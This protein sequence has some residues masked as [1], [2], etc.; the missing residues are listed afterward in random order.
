MSKIKFT[1]FDNRCFTTL[2]K[3]INAPLKIKRT[4]DVSTL[5][6]SAVE[7]HFRQRDERAVNCHPRSELPLPF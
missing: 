3:P 4:F 5:Y 2:S 1:P 7:G 6:T